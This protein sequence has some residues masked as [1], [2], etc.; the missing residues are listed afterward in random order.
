MAIYGWADLPWIFEFRL[1]SFNFI[2]K[3][4]ADVEKAILEALDRQYA[5]VLS[6]LKDTSAPKTFGFKYMQKISKRSVNMYFV[7]D[8]VIL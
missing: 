3:A 4:T 8:E 6:P 5:D 7:P 1:T 2:L